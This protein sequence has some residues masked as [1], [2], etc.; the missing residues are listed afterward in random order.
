MQE[1]QEFNNLELPLQTLSKRMDRKIRWRLFKAY[2]KK[3]FSF[4]GL[5][6]LRWQTA[7]A[8]VLLPVAIFGGYFGLKSY[9]Y[10][11]DGITKDDLFYSWKREMEIEIL[12]QLNSPEEK[13]D[14]YLDLSDRR[15]AE[16]SSEAKDKGYISKS[17]VPTVY[18]A[19]MTIEDGDENDNEDLN[20]KNS[21][22]SKKPQQLKINLQG[23]TYAELVSESSFFNSL[24]IQESKKI[25]DLNLRIV[26]IEEIDLHLEEQEEILDKIIFE[27]DLPKTAYDTVVAVQTT[28]KENKKILEK[29]KSDPKNLEFQNIETMWAPV[30][31]EA[32]EKYYFW[33]IIELEHVDANFSI[34]TDQLDNDPKDLD[35]DQKDS[36]EDESE[37][38]DGSGDSGT[39]TSDNDLNST[40]SDK[41]VSD[42][43][44]TNSDSE[45][46]KTETD[47]KDL[48]SKD[49]PEEPK[50]TYQP[51]PGYGE[52]IPDYDYEVKYPDLN[53][54]PEDTTEGGGSEQTTDSKTEQQTSTEEK[55]TDFGGVTIDYSLWKLPTTTIPTDFYIPPDLETES[56]STSTIESTYPKLNINSKDLFINPDLLE[57]STSD[58]KLVQPLPDLDYSGS[59]SAN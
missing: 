36:E 38:K 55:N 49:T 24:A 54:L 26:K 56:G 13:V 22:S 4:S 23:D 20:T 41:K 8:L 40:D 28:N 18:A 51:I 53:F 46:L 34:E 39:K 58:F 14:F 7:M 52:L 15:L 5:T 21:E 9:V 43:D 30:E 11:S 16:S 47:S 6:N 32:N 27:G 12:A 50:S 44:L 35:E 42:P 10:S 45:N 33:Q 25:G 59:Q 31:F 2:L 1:N 19:T 48:D 3:K 17:L 37:T 57:S 29:Q